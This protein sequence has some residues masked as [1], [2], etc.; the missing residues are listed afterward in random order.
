MITNIYAANELIEELQEL[1]VKQEND[2]AKAAKIIAEQDQLI[3]MQSVAVQIGKLTV[4]LL[5][6]ELTEESD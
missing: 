6:A 5:K 3:K 4:N 2:L 1:A